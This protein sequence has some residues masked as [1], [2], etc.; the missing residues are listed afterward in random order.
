M[1]Y[2]T[3]SFAKKTAQELEAEFL[4]IS[5]QQVKDSAKNLCVYFWTKDESKTQLLSNV[6]ITVAEE[7]KCAVD[8][9]SYLVSDDLSVRFMNSVIAANKGNEPN[10]E[11][12]T[13][14]QKEVMD[15]VTKIINSSMRTCSEK[16]M[17]RR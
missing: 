6:G 11:N 17:R 16:L 4:A 15:Q 1:F 10:A 13:S 2:S 14:S 3:S 5:K 8:E 7:C 9:T 12:L